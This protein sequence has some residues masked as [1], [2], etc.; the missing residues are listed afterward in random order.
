MLGHTERNSGSVITSSRSGAVV[1]LSWYWSKEVW[2][3]AVMDRKPKENSGLSA[4][5]LNSRVVSVIFTVKSC[6]N[7]GSLQ[8]LWWLSVLRKGGS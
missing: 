2:E 7:K 8:E 5:G 3:V 1:D 6:F 4:H